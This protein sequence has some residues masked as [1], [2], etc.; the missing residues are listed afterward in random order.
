MQVTAEMREHARREYGRAQGHFIRALQALDCPEQTG[1]IGEVIA[2]VGSYEV[3]QGLKLCMRRLRGGV[4]YEIGEED[5]DD[6]RVY[7]DNAAVRGAWRLI[8]LTEGRKLGWF[9]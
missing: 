1:R 4:V 9:S 2:E 5:G 7:D 8:A 6:L 3:N